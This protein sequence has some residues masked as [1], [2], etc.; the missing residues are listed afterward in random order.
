MVDL[1][2]GFDY[3]SEARGLGF[4]PYYFSIYLMSISISAIYN[5]IESVYNT[6]HHAKK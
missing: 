5:L 6:K 2:A 3:V 4:Y 1:P